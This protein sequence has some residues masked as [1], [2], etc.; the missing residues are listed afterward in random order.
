MTS[1]TTGKDPGGS[2]K[3][4]DKALFL[5]DFFLPDTPEWRLSDL[6]R[7]AGMDKVTVMRIL[8]SLAVKGIVE[9]HPEFEKIPSW[10][11]RSSSRKDQRGVLSSGS[12]SSAC[13]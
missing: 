9:Q 11:G 3:T 10:N 8:K 6:A 4:I 13:S 7:A 2:M 1:H 5:L 12:G